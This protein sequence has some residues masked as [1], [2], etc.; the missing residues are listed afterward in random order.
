MLKE[1]RLSQRQIAQTLGVSR[2]TVNAIASGR[3]REGVA[4][5]GPDA[6]EDG[7]TLPMGIPVR[8]PGCGGLTQMPCLLCYLRA[9]S[10][11]E[12]PVRSGLCRQPNRETIATATRG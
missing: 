3:R 10:D 8:C 7:F 1:G 12:K 11:A 2:G 6:R 9:R 4:R 5:R